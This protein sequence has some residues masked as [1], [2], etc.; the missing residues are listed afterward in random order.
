MHFALIHVVGPIWFLVVVGLR[1]PFLCNLPG[2]GCSQLLEATHISGHVTP[3]F[4]ASRGKYPFHEM[5]FT[6]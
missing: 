3:V 5:P 1:S 6:L 4:K 2:G